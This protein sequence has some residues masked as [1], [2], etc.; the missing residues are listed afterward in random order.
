MFQNAWVSNTGL[1][2]KK[3][4]DS[5]LWSEFNAAFSVFPFSFKRRKDKP[6]NRL[7]TSV[8]RK[9]SEIFLLIKARKHACRP[10]K[11]RRVLSG[12]EGWC[13]G[14][15]EKKKHG[16]QHV[17][18]TAQIKTLS[19]RQQALRPRHKHWIMAFPW[20]LAH[21]QPHYS[22]QEGRKY[23]FTYEGGRN[24]NLLANKYR[25]KIKAEKNN[26]FFFI[27]CFGT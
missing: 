16:C 7:C 12:D 14:Y 11:C 2:L 6:K 3:A 18:A 20:L 10:Q 26:I 17:S 24:V 15:T 4:S 8:K 5:H 9:R 13:L 27:I 21:G 22:W 1:I 23:D 19:A 25:R